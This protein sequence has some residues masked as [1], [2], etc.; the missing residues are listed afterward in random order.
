MSHLLQWTLFTNGPATPAQPLL[1]NF[2]VAH[3]AN[4][5]ETRQLQPWKHATTLAQCRAF[6][7]LQTNTIILVDTHHSFVQDLFATIWLQQY[8]RQRDHPSVH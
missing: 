1:T 8:P 7:N 5:K 4:R 3:V 2:S 6:Y